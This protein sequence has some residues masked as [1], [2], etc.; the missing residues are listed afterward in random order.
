[1]LNLPFAHMALLAFLK[2]MDVKQAKISMK[3]K[4]LI[5]VNKPANPPGTNL[6]S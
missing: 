2:T 3:L 5:P 1:L 4:I 6:W